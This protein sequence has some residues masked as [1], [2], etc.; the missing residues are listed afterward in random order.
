MTE[1]QIRQLIS[2]G[3]IH[4]FY[5]SPDWRRKRRATLKAQKYECQVCK[6]RGRY[7]RATIVHHVQRLRDRP[8]LALA[9]MDPETGRVQLMA[10]CKQC[11]DD[12][13][14]DNLFRRNKYKYDEKW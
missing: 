10:V 12:I 6:S 14:S 5:D 13:H 1:T 4:R 9:D 7:T 3:Q 8:D 11:H 2:T